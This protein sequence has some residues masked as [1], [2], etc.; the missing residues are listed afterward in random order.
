MRTGVC[1]GIEVDGALRLRDGPRALHERGLG[2][3]VQDA[4][5]QFDRVDVVERERGLFH[6]AFDLRAQGTPDRRERNVDHGTTIRN[7]DLPDHAEFD[8]GGPEFGVQH[9]SSG[10]LAVDRRIARSDATGE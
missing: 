7:R 2:R 4:H 5:D 8:D 1:V 9:L 10:V 3:G 6:V